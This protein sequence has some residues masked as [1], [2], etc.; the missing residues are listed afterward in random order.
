LAG[1]FIF[2]TRAT[3]ASMHRGHTPPPTERGTTHFRRN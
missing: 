2:S 3:D 1:V